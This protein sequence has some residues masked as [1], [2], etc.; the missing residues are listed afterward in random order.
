M[1]GQAAPPGE[2]GACPAN[3]PVYTEQDSGVRM[4]TSR[5]NFIQSASIASLGPLIAARTASAQRAKSKRDRMLDV[6]N[7]SAKP[8]YIP[9]GFFMHF[10]VK[11]DA[12]V[13]AH[14]DHF[15]GTGMDFVKI[16]FD[17]QTFPANDQVKTP[18]DWARLP[19]Q[20]EKW[21]EPTLYLLK[22]LIQ[23][24]KSEAL[25]IQTLYSPY[26]LAKQAV[27][28]KLLVEHVKQDADSVCRGM[29]NITLSLVHF[30]QAAARLGVDG[31]YTCTQGGETNYIADRGLFNRAV[32]NYDMMLY[33][34]TAQL[35]PYNIMHVCDYEGSYQ[36]F[37]ARFQDYP[38][39][40]VNVPLSA[41][42]KPLSLRRAAEIFKRPVM[43]G[44]DRLGIISTGTPEQ[45]KKAALEVLK[46]A[47]PN[48]ILGAD[49]T[50]SAKTPR[51]NLR[52]IIQAAHEF[53]G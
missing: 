18:K 29:E 16:Q 25:I 24:A 36:D 3:L 20:P 49:C 45:A 41:D 48:F 44:L 17:E 12:A 53:R 31:F 19:I 37:T 51:E 30:V 23:E 46:D 7:T 4:N 43:G 34:E 50:V 1:A 32:K 52:A 10:G 27:P 5:R 28:A 47:P 33:K 39:Q 40:V 38:G 8:G 2:T 6:L 13:K 14:L 21:F 11:G 35:V 26:Q 15:R 9:A 42:G 22:R